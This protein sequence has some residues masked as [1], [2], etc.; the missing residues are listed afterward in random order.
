MNKCCNLNLEAMINDN[1]Q[2]KNNSKCG[3]VHIK[4]DNINSIQ[5]LP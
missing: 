1:F 3:S 4:L 2:K 5:I